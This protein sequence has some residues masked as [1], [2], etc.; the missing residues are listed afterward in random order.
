MRNAIAK[1][2]RQIVTPRVSKHRLFVWRSVHVLADSAT[3]VIARDDD[4]TFGILQSRFHEIWSL[5]LCTWLGVGNDPRYTPSTTFETFPFPE[6]LSPDVPASTYAGDPKAV[7]IARAARRLDELRNNWCNPS[8]L[9]RREPGILQHFPARILPIDA[10]AAEIL[11]KRTLTNLYNE[12][13][14]WLANA[15]AELDAAVA[16]AYGWPAD[17]SEDDALAR[18]FELNQERAAQHIDQGELL[19]E[20]EAEN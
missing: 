19:A 11:K 7:G 12:R 18:L 2:S 4:T 16:E 5:K 9:V 15:H 10:R 13:P 17:V 20:A 3:V 1:I 8:D 14:T 6:N